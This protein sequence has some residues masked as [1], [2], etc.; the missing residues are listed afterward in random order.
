M[1]SRISAAAAEESASYYKSFHDGAASVDDNSSQLNVD[2]DANC[3]KINTGRTD[4]LDSL[5]N[6]GTSFDFYSPSRKDK[7]QGAVVGKK[8]NFLF[9]SFR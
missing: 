4:D 5:S 3:E 6:T 1:A 2:G 8:K 9:L 7:I